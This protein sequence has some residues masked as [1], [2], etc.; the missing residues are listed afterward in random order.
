MGNKDPFELPS[1]LTDYVKE[2]ASTGT[3]IILILAEGRP[4]LLNGVADVASA[5][6][7]AG[8]PCE[9]GGEA[10]SEVLFGK[11][12]FSGKMALTY[13]K[14]DDDL[15]MATPYYGR[16]GDMC[17]VDGVESSCPVEWQFGEG[18]SYTTFDYSN[19]QLSTTSLTPDADQVT[20]TV[21]VTN[22]GAMKGKEAVLLFVS[23]PGLL[24]ETKLL[25]KYTKIELDVG[26]STDI[27]F[28]LS[29]DDFGAYVNEIGDGLRKE[30]SSGTYFIGLK[31]DTI[32]G[33]DSIG[34]LCQ[35]FEW[36]N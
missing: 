19:M 30:A 34:D 12:N 13:P 23:A 35:S 4:R 15:N 10:I 16:R 14:T 20:V 6:V 18:L 21:T 2:L 33:P 11:E 29:S 36:S 26:Q 7:Y 8:L 32:C 28:T 3:K 5:I 17:V 22:S 27:N 24:P 25:K 1:G 31:F 9:M